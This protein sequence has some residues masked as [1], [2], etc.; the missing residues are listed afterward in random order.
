MIVDGHNDLVLHRWR[1]EPTMHMD[2]D[3]ARDAGFAGGFFALYVPSPRFPDPTEIPYAVPLADPIPHEE[4]A[5][6]AEELFAALC[7]LPVAAGDRCGRVP[8]GRGHGD[9]PHGGR[10]ADRARPLEPR[11]VVRAGPAV[12]RADLVAAERVRRGRAVPVPV[13][14]GHG[15]RAD[16]GRARARCGVQ[17]TRDPRRPVA[18]ELGRASGTSRGSPT[19]R[20]SR[21]TRT[22]TRSAPRRAT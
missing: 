10:G 2:L 9:R 20:S 13:V 11:V 19:R 1:G 6:I 22:R 5:R 17:P 8:R 7:A 3:A 12:D 4:A 14:A 15:R 16:R 18:P 21:R